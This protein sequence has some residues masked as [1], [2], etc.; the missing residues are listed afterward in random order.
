MQNF[1]VVYYSILKESK[2]E[3]IQT[4]QVEYNSNYY[5]TSIRRIAHSEHEYDN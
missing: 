2:V 1:Y 3:N 5:G 4:T